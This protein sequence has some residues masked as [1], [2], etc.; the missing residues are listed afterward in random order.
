MSKET[1]KVY[2]ETKGYAEHIATF[3]CESAYV[4]SIPNL[5]RWAKLNGFLSI[6]E[7]VET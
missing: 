7:S 4:V 1:I 5:E 6:T 3:H 2:A